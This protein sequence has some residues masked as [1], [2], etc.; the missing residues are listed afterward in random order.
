MSEAS[1]P[2]PRALLAIE[3]ST[4][5]CLR[6]LPYLSWRYG[7]A[8]HAALR[9]DNAQLMTTA[10]NS[11]Q[12]LAEVLEWVR[13]QNA[14]RGLPGLVVEIALE[15]MAREARRQLPAQQEQMSVALRHVRD[16]L[17]ARRH[18]S[19]SEG[20]LH[21]CAGH[22]EARLGVQPGRLWSGFGALLAS[23]VADERSGDLQLVGQL[24]AWA[25]DER[26][27]GEPW[28]GAVADTLDY[29]RRI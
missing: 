4:Q 7:E 17:R 23:A 25:S 21:R 13:S 10:L 2:E 11:P 6:A 24:R 9:D 28:L 15:C 27:F 3:R 22:F 5:L 16:E 8:G 26:R 14:R 29:A 19:M 18:K 20:K 12:Q 1:T